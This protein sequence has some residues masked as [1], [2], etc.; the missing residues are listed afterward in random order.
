RVLELD[1]LPKLALVVRDATDLPVHA[2]ALDS[3]SA[4][5]PEAFEPVTAQYGDVA[6][7][8]WT[9]GTTGRSKGVMQSHNAWVRSAL[10]TVETGHMGLGDVIYNCMPL[11][12]SAAWVAAIYPALLSG[13]PCAMDPAFSASRFWDRTRHYGATHVF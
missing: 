4:R 5:V 9:S 7:I 8:M 10:S 6:S 11:Y 2:I 3:L 13:A 1:G 12:N